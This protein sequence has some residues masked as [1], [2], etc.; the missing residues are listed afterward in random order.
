MAEALVAL[1]GKHH[2]E[3]DEAME[4]GYKIISKIKE[5]TDRFSN[6]FDLNFVCYA[7]PAEGLSGRFIN[8]DRKEF[9]YIMGVTDKTYYSNSYH[10][11]VNYDI[12]IFEKIKKEAPFHKLCAAGHISYVELPSSP[13]G[14]KEAFEKILNYMAESDMGYAGINFP[15]DECRVCGFSG[16]IDDNCPNCESYNIRRIRRI[17]G[18]LSTIDRFNDAKLAELFDRK[19]HRR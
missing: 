3:S 8:I 5:A 18:Y 13:K 7:T 16:I 11:P 10:I 12:S 4:L 17:T 9:G 1:T 19:I 14:N 15:I 6:T 2:G